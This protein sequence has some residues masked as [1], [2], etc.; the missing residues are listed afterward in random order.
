MFYRFF[1]WIIF[2]FEEVFFVILQKQSNPLFMKKQ[3][4]LSFIII[5][6]LSNAQAPINDYFGDALSEYALVTGTVDNS[7]TGANATWNF[8]G[9]TQTDTNTD[10]FAAP[11]AVELSSYPGTTQV[12]TITDTGMNTN[13]VFHALSGSTLS[14]TGASNPEFTLDYNTDNAEIGTYPLT[15]GSPTN[16]DNIAG[17]IFAQGQ[18]ANY[19]GTI[20]TTVDAHGNLS[21]DV[22]GLGSYNGNVT[23]I[24]TTQTISFTI[25]F[26]FPGTAVITSYY[27]YKDSDG[28]LAFRTNDGVISVPGLD[29]NE[30]FSTREGLV[31]NTL[32]TDETASQNNTIKLYPNPVND[33]LHIQLDN[34]VSIQ[35]ITIT[36]IN[37]RTVLNKKDIVDTINTSQLQSGFYM[38]SISTDKGLL[39]KEFIKN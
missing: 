1:L 30:G 21:F 16:T 33:Y 32:S 14:L 18:T 37:G 4:L 17:T 7:P 2:R 6:F 5:S 20:N 12:L 13:Q 25:A 36:D 9:L 31:T 39:T 19:T 24:V 35:S 11:T 10:T 15:F 23:R 34:S 28:S 29:I 38:I 22:V 8:S 27:Y 26:V 3:L